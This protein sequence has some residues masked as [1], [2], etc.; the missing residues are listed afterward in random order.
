[1]ATVKCWIKKIN[2]GN[3]IWSNLRKPDSE[4]TFDSSRKSPRFVLN[5]QSR[6]PFSLQTTK[7]HI[8]IIKD[9]TKNLYQEITLTRA[10]RQANGETKGQRVQRQNVTTPIDSAQLRCM[11]REN[12]IMKKMVVGWNDEWI[13]LRMF[14]TK[15]YEECHVEKC[16]MG[17]FL[18]LEHE[19]ENVT[20]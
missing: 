8:N 12:Q 15:T 19:R 6:W 1:M 4:W 2:N 11:Y 17:Y 10:A 9:V 5:F 13:S 3:L 16:R 20:K 7:R 18:P 14:V